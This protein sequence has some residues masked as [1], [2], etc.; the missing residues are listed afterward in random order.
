LDLL[1][2]RTFE[3]TLH[4]VL[5]TTGEK[6]KA[7]ARTITVLTV[8]FL[9]ILIGALMAQGAYLKPS[10]MTTPWHHDDLKP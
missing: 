6:G 3:A 1:A 5:T 9:S 10:L 8:C 4:Q 2:P 7:V